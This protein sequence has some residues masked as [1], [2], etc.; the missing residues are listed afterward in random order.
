M[1][2]VPTT[3]II[4]RIVSLLRTMFK[5]RAAPEHKLKN[6]KLWN[7]G[8]S[9]L[10]IFLETIS[11]LSMTHQHHLPQPSTS[12]RTLALV[13]HPRDY[14][15]SYRPLRCRSRS[16]SAPVLKLAP[17]FTYNHYQLA[18][19]LCYSKVPHATP[20]FNSWGKLK[21]CFETVFGIYWTSK[22]KTEK[23]KLCTSLL[24][25]RWCVSNSVSRGETM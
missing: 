9:R 16:T 24:T 4:L 18:L 8:N 19:K 20:I 25:T 2:T 7:K 11:V 10:F 15:N 1:T 3:V 21:L 22:L 23:H 14:S 6:G 5:E 13:L 17:A 12:P